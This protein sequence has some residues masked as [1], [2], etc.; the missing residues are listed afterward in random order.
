MIQRTAPAAIA[1]RYTKPALTAPLTF[2]RLL[3]AIAR[4]KS[5]Q[6]AALY[7]H[8]VATRGAGP[9]P[10]VVDMAELAEELTRRSPPANVFTQDRAHWGA[11][12][13]VAVGLWELR[14]LGLSQPALGP[15]G[16]PQ[17]LVV[18]LGDHTLLPGPHTRKAHIRLSALPA[19][20]EWPGV[21]LATF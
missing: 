21:V 11:H 15:A 17:R 9:P 12:W 10:F 5:R 19:G 3:I 20:E 1:P 2:E 13:S 18:W 16:R 7:A 8:L 4:R 14:F 6:T